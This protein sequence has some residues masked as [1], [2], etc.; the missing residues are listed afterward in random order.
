MN[1]DLSCFDVKRPAMRRHTTRFTLVLLL[2]IPFGL[3]LALLL[4]VRL[5]LVPLQPVPLLLVPLLLV[6]LL[7]LLLLL[8]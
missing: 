5:L 2:C 7:V 4:L 6:L 1:V 8:V 3:L